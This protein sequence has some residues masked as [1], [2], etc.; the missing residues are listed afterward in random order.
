MQGFIATVRR[1]FSSI[2]LHF[3]GS[4]NERKLK[5]FWARVAEINALEPGFVAKSDDELKAMT[6]RLK[7]RLS[8]GE[9][10][11]AI[12]PE[13]F[14]TV[15]EASR[16]ILDMRHFDSQLVG[17]IMLHEGKIA[18]MATLVEA[19]RSLLYRAAMK[20]DKG[21]IDPEIIAMAKWYCCEI[22]VKFES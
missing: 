7:E 18:E 16:R 1:F 15:R 3:F 21:E 19:G 11:D 22:A 12:L 20:V 10:L 4:A 2:A 14:A 6:P 9:D 8:A 17:G 13:A 5:R